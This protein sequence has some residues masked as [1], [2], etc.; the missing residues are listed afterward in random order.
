MPHD[1]AQKKFWTESMSVICCRNG[2]NATRFWSGWCLT[3]EHGWC[4]RILSKSGCG[5][6]SVVCPKQ[7]PSQDCT[8]CFV[9]LEGDHPIKFETTGPLE[10]SYWT[11]ACRFGQQEECGVPPVHCQTTHLL[12]TCQKLQQLGWEI[13]SPPPHIPD[14]APSDY[15]LILFMTSTLGGVELTS[16]EA[17][18]KWRSEFFAKKEEISRRRYYKVAVYMKTGYQTKRQIF[19]QS[20]I[21]VTRF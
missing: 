11:E 14:I 3:T 13:L 10:A 5:G 12:L 1:L 7:W 6:R 2:T 21:T 15:H 16:K 19:E 9:G 4:M 8:V 17:S 20:P 18:K